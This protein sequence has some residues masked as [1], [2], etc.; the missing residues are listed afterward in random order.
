MTPTFADLASIPYAL[1]CV[2]LNGM[3]SLYSTSC[4]LWHRPFNYPSIWMHIARLIN[5]NT[6][7][8]H[9]FGL[10]NVVILSITL[11]Y[12]SYRVKFENSITYVALFFVF[13]AASPVVLLLE[14]RGNIDTIIFAILTLGAMQ[15]EKGRKLVSIAFASFATVLKIFPIGFLLGLFVT[16]KSVKAR[17]MSIFIALCTILYLSGDWV[18]IRNNTPQPS[19]GAFGMILN[20]GIFNVSANK[21]LNLLHAIVSIVIFMCFVALFD[22]L[23]RSYKYQKPNKRTIKIEGKFQQPIEVWLCLNLFIFIL[24]ANFLYRLIFLIP[25]IVHLINSEINI[26]RKLGFSLLPL[27]YV[28]LWIPAMDLIT[29]FYLTLCL[30][31]LTAMVINLRAIK[32]SILLEKIASFRR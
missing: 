32:F 18:E 6:N 27:F 25:L 24:S 15:L 26:Y 1:K 9:L 30:S 16:S 5:L 21:P 19:R 12:W 28:S 8:L 31:Y 22:A 29:N 7:F 17:V 23:K 11:G 14:E 10:L 3:Q 13:L 20:R 2:N 4:D